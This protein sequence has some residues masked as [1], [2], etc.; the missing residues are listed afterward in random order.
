MRLMKQAQ[1]AKL[2]RQVIQKRR[3]EEGFTQQIS[4]TQ[5]LSEAVN[6]KVNS[7]S[8]Y[9]LENLC[10]AECEELAQVLRPDDLD[11]EEALHK[12]ECELNRLMTFAPDATV[13]TK[14]HTIEPWLDPKQIAVRQSVDQAVYTH[15]ATDYLHWLIEG[16]DWTK[17][18]RCNIPA[19]LTEKQMVDFLLSPLTE[20]LSFSDFRSLGL[21]PVST[22]GRVSLKRQDTSPR[23]GLTQ[24]QEMLVIT[25]V[26][27]AET[28][29]YEFDVEIDRPN[30]NTE[31]LSVTRTGVIRK[32]KY[33]SNSPVHCRR[34]VRDM[35][36]KEEVQWVPK[37]PFGDSLTDQSRYPGFPYFT[38]RSFPESVAW[39]VSGYCEMLV[40]NDCYHSEDTALRYLL[41]QERTLEL[42]FSASADSIYVSHAAAILR[43]RHTLI[44]PPWILPEELADY[45]RQVRPKAARQRRLPTVESVELFCFVVNN[46]LPGTEP[47]WSSLVRNWNTDGR[48]ALTRDKL[49][50][51]YHSVRQA[52]F[53]SRR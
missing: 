15:A 50:K 3:A 27:S 9:I 14:D 47:K 51:V 52:L 42:G 33:C 12:I 40:D 36:G 37:H 21:C 20:V 19:G 53:P 32:L 48:K 31:F 8:D 24:A 2:I 1:A 5:W 29:T 39:E 35:A 43:G 26:Q 6:Q 38:F 13:R 46:T 18:F 22:Q 11:L 16:D 10:D 7:A 41:M 17:D 30:G 28:T 4:G 45:W 49:Y 25:G 44:V 23:V 34:N